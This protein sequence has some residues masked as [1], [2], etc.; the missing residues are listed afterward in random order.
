MNRKA[1][2]ITLSAEERAELDRIARTHTAPKRMA[3]R[4]QIILWGAEGRRDPE[5]VQRLRTRA[6]RICK[7]RPRFVRERSEGLLDEPQSRQPRT[8]TSAP[9]LASQLSYAYRTLERMS[10][11]KNSWKRVVKNTN[12][13]NENRPNLNLISCSST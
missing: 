10:R 12:S 6:A 3:E 9:I 4:A 13:S 11:V 1:K 5:V 7:L 8:Y 2:G